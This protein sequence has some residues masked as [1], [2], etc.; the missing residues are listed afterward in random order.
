[1]AA[2]MDII[3]ARDVV[4]VIVVEHEFTRM[5]VQVRGIV[6]MIMIRPTMPAA[7]GIPSATVMSVPMAMRSPDID[8]HSATSNMNALRMRRGCIQI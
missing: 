8:V 3:V 1:M 7:I 5:V 4:V 2:A 6:P